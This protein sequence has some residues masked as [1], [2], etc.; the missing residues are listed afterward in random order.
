MSPSRLRELAQRPLVEPAPLPEPERCDLCG[1]P[2][3]PEHR[4]VLDLASGQPECACRACSILFDRGAAGGDHYRLIP[5]RRL[6]LQD[7]AV[8]ARLW[9]ALGIPV[10]LA[11]VT[12]ADG[13]T[14]LARYPAPVGLI[15]SAPARDAWAQMTDADPVLASMEPD[16]EA[17]L[18]NRARGANER[19]LVPVDDCFRLAAVLREHWTGFQGGDVVW[20]EIARFFAALNEEHDRKEARCR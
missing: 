8:D 6:R 10:D 18:L 9:A 5:E 13:G 3:P 15:T 19:W 12:V 4:H 14:P 20:Q 11:F 2:L 1:E 17:L 16:V 7:R